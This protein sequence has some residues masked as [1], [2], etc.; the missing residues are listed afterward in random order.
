[1]T[2]KIIF[3][4]VVPVTSADKSLASSSAASIG[5]G[6]DEGLLSVPVASSPTGEASP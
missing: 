5:S 2:T 1:M 6:I 4:Q 3:I